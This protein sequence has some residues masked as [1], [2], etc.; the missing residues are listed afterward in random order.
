M[1]KWDLSV[2]DAF[3]ILEKAKKV[4]GNNEK[5]AGVWS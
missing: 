2:V 5:V 4:K 1:S 3:A